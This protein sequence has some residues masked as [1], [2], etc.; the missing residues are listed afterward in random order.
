MG[1]DSAQDSCP[2]PDRV[3]HQGGDSGE[4]SPTLPLNPKITA[5]TDETEDEEILRLALGPVMAA[6]SSSRQA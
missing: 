6:L 3:K 4:A 5:R 2:M 1:L